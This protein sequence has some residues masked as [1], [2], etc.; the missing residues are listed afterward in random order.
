[1]H[2]KRGGS[3]ED[4]ESAGFEIEEDGITYLVLNQMD[5]VGGD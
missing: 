2:N 1:L 5:I 3:G 4:Q